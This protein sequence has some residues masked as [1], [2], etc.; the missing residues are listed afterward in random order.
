M[1]HHFLQCSLFLEKL[2]ENADNYFPMIELTLKGSAGLEEAEELQEF[3][4]ETGLDGEEA[5]EIWQDLQ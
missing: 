3:K 1:L 2:Q 4:D 5:L